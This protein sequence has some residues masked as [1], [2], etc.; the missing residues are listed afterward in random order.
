VQQA[1]C[2]D[3]S[4]PEVVDEAAVEEVGAQDG[5]VDREQIVAEA[6]EGDGSGQ[7]GE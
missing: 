7:D 4:T 2:G 5:E 1:L 3:A 6:E